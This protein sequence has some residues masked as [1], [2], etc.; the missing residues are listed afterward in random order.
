MKFTLAFLKL[1]VIVHKL[2]LVLGLL[3]LTLIAFDR[4]FIFGLLFLYSIIG[5]WQV[6][7]TLILGLG[8]GLKSRVKYIVLVIAFG[9]GCLLIS[10][11]PGQISKILFPLWGFLSLPMAVYYTYQTFEDRKSFKNKV[12]QVHKIYDDLILES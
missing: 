7:S 1:D 8:C 6:F 12:K 11:L 3:G 9:V 4:M 2:L 10:V 5:G